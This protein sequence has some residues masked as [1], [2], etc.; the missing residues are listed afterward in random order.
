MATMPF[1]LSAALAI[2]C[3]N[4]NNDD[5]GP[6][7]GGSMDGG[8]MDGGG[9]GG[10]VTN[11]VDG[12]GYPE[13]VDCNDNNAAVNPGATEVCNGIDDNCDGVIDTDAV[14]TVTYYADRD[15][16]G[17]GNPMDTTQSCGTKPPDGYVS[18]SLDCRDSNRDMNPDGREV[19][20]AQN[21]DEDCDGLRDDQD[22]SADVLTM[23][24]FYADYD[25]DGFGDANTIVQGCDP[26]GIRSLNDLDCDDTNPNVGPG[27]S[28][29]P[30]DGTWTGDY[31][32]D[33][34]GVYDYT[35]TCD[36]TSSI[37][38]SDGAT[39]Q[40]S[41][42]LECAWYSAYPVLLRLQG[43]LDYPWGVTG[44]WTDDYNWFYQDGDWNTDLTGTFSEDGSTLSLK[45]TGSRDS[46]FG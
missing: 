4:N 23:T 31:S 37:T 8:S 33:V 39:P 46:L 21:L 42:Y 38:I 9:D 30:F 13:G 34:H 16:D 29:A 11:D 15:G 5:S 40:V 28:C 6:S 19:C 12:D 10:A 45:L 41:A 18:N 7:D 20:D 43:T 35:G 44:Y 22:P 14:D 27:P 2:G 32:F 36:G 26:G 1:L 17:Y 3:G 24:S 25:L